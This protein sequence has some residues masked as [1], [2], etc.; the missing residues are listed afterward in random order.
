MGLGGNPEPGKSDP[1]LQ[2]EKLSSRGRG[3]ALKELR[4]IRRIWRILRIWEDLEDLE[5]LE[6]L[7][8]LEDLGGSGRI[9]EDLGGSGGSLEGLRGRT[10]VRRGGQRGRAHGR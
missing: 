4:R 9:W 2:T 8:D 3:G 7:E 10:Q 6:D 5:N 1:E